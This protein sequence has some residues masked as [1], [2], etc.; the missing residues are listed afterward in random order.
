MLAEMNTE[1]TRQTGGS[2]ERSLLLLQIL[3]RNDRGMTLAEVAEHLELPKATVHRLCNRLL[4]LKFI[5]RDVDERLYVAGP[6]LRQLAFDTLTHG[7][8]SRLRH[9]VL[10]E[11]VQEIGETCNF[12][13]LDGASVLYLDRVEA[14]RPWR[15]TLDVGVHVPLHC[16]ASGKLFLAH[17]LADE[18]RKLLRSLS[19]ESLTENSMTMPDAVEREA[20]QTLD[21]GYAVDNEEFIIGLVAVA[22]PVFDHSNT[23]KAAIAMH[24]P[25]SHVTR[26]QAVERVPRLMVAA[27]R[28]EALLH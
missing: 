13:T 8:V 3:S 6:A 4:K 28:M 5:S 24:C 21:T 12:T 27:R 11:L 9:M 15:M 7:T 17:M 19:L 1:S 26:E 23:I 25:T 2:A 14:K 22:V 18:R 20:L 16:T 10:N